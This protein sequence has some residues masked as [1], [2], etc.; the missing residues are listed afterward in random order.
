MKSRMQERLD[1]KLLVFSLVPRLSPCPNKNKFFVRARG[2]P[3]NEANLCSCW[4]LWLICGGVLVN[5]ADSTLASFPGSAHTREPGNEADST[6]DLWGGIC[7]FVVFQ[8]TLSIL[9]VVSFPDG[10]SYWGS[11][12]ET[13][14]VVKGN[15]KKQTTIDKTKTGFEADPPLWGEVSLFVVFKLTLSILI[16]VKSNRKRKTTVLDR[17][18][19]VYSWRPGNLHRHVRY[20]QVYATRMTPTLNR[21]SAIHRFE[22]LRHQMQWWWGWEGYLLPTSARL[23]DVS[24]ECSSC[25]QGNDNESKRG[26]S[27]FP[28]SSW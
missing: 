2:K 1:M 24:I 19:A 16:V 11:G 6:S 26:A 3:G 23:A 17:T 5:E 14:L 7:L 8:L 12:N 10:T 25:H 18:V 21:S 27:Y 20:W 9:V 22:Q 15:K 13:I 4:E 28:S